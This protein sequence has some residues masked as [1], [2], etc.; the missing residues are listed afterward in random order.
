MGCEMI[1]DEMKIVKLSNIFG[2]EFKFFDAAT[3]R[4]DG[5]REEFVDVDGVMCIRILNENMV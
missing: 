2:V 5:E 3:Y 4:D 1:E